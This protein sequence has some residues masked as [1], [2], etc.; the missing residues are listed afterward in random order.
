M[1]TTTLITYN[2]RKK[3]RIDMPDVSVAVVDGKGRKGWKCPIS[4][5]PRIEERHMRRAYLLYHPREDAEGHSGIQRV[6]RMW[7]N[8]TLVFDSV[9]AGYTCAGLVN[10]SHAYEI[11]RAVQ[12][13]KHEDTAL[14]PILE[15]D[16]E[17]W[18]AQDIGDIQPEK[19]FDKVSVPEVMERIQALHPSPMWPPD[20]SGADD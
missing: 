6:G 5:L 16:D 4:S 8:A 10:H 17:V 1:T 7:S 18:V 20:T 15:W 9:T 2:E 19:S 13:Q 12:Q 3:T 11:A 14:A